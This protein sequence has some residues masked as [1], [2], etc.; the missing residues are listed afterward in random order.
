MADFYRVYE[1][2]VRDGKPQQYQPVLPAFLI[3][4]MFVKHALGRKEPV[5]LSLPDVDIFFLPLKNNCLTF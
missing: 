5:E 3:L 2:S 1:C 4:S